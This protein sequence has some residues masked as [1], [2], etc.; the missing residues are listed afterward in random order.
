MSYGEDIRIKIMEDMKPALTMSNGENKSFED[1]SEDEKNKLD[2]LFEVEEE[3]VYREYT[4]PSDGIVP[5]GTYR[6]TFTYEDFSGYAYINVHPIDLNESEA[7]AIKLIIN[8]PKELYYNQNI[9]MQISG[10][11]AQKANITGVTLHFKSQ[12]TDNTE[13]FEAT[14][15]N[16]NIILSD[17]D[18]KL[19]PGEWEV[20]ARIKSTNY[21]NFTTGTTKLNIKKVALTGVRYGI[22]KYDPWAEKLEEQYTSVTSISY[23]YDFSK[24]SLSDYIKNDYYHYLIKL[25]SNN[26][27][28]LMDENNNVLKKNSEGKWCI[29]NENENLIEYTGQIF[30]PF[31]YS[32][33]FL[34]AGGEGSNYAKIKLN[35]DS[36]ITTTESTYYPNI[37]ITENENIYNF[38]GGVISKPIKIEKKAVNIQYYRNN[39]QP[40]T[41]DNQEHT[42]NIECDIS[43]EIRKVENKYYYFV[44]TSDGNEIKLFEITNYSNKNAGKYTSQCILTA[45]YQNLVTLNLKVDSVADENNTGKTTIILPEREILMKQ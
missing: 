27:P 19:T 11:N 12:E 22:F 9:V 40:I 28:I 23:E 33:G 38:G 25:D 29:E 42:V 30:F 41:Y 17:N 14:Y 3:N 2:F 15:S 5:I 45:D 24:T 31:G 43:G 6:V 36:K 21:E 8:N 39:N 10:F 1:F 13:E 20:C 4:L 7:Q 34:Y 26:E 18:G 32:F 44:E 35:N 16:G 37:S